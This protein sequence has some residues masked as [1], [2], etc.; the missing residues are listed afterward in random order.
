MRLSSLVLAY[1]LLGAILWGG[2]AIH[3]NEAGVGGFFMHVDQGDVAHNANT[4]GQLTNLSG[5]IQIASSSIAG[6][7][8]AAIWNII[9]KLVGYLFWPITVMQ[10]NNMPPRI[11]VVLGGSLVVAFYGSLLRILRGTI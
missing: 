10:T 4:T 7:G 3:W 2:G 9:V 1:F 8:L 6:G 11:T 5:P